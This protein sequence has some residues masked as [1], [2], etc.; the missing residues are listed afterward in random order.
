MIFSKGG[1]LYLI[2]A[3]F[4]IG[5]SESEL[6]DSKGGDK[7]LKSYLKKEPVVRSIEDLGGTYGPGLLIKTDHYDIYTTVQDVLMLRQ[8]PVFLEN[9]QSEYRK[10]SGVDSVSKNRNK[11]YIFE[12]RE[13]WESFGEYFTAELWPVINESK[14]VLITLREPVLHTISVEQILSL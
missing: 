5:C 9:V 13:Q 11:I 7:W 8:I 10:I 1:L 6:A 14:K 4:M 2:L 12:T 3:V